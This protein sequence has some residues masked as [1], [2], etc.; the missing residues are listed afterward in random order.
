VHELICSAASVF[1]RGETSV[2]D[3]TYAFRNAMNVVVS[4]R[5]LEGDEVL[6]FDTLERWE[7]SGWSGRPGIVDQLRTLVAAALEAAQND[8]LT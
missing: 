6:I 3:F 1:L 2:T 7:A 4:D 8:R 5:L